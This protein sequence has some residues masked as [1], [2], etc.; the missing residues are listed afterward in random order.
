MHTSTLRNWDGSKV[1]YLPLAHNEWDSTAKTAQTNVLYSFGR[2]DRWIGL[3]A[4]TAYYGAMDWLT[5]VEPQLARGMF[6]AVADLQPRGRS[7]L[8]RHHQ[9][10]RRDRRRDSSGNT[11]MGSTGRRF[12]EEYKQLIQNPTI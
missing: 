9:H 2:A 4:T 7:D 6:N 8:L 10:L 11:S 5:A 3:R 1:S 12:T